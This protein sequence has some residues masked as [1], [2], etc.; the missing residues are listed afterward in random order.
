MCQNQAGCDTT[1]I[2]DFAQKLN[3]VLKATPFEI[4]K[5]NV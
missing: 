2:T 1:Q 5:Y 4:K 3:P